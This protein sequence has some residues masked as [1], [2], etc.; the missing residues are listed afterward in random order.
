MASGPTQSRFTESE[1]DSYHSE[2]S[3]YSDEEY[4]YSENYSDQDLIS[5]SDFNEF[6]EEASDNEVESL[7]GTHSRKRELSYDQIVAIRG[8]YKPRPRRKKFAGGRRVYK[9][10]SRLTQGALT[11]GTKPSWTRRAKLLLADAQDWARKQGFNLLRKTWIKKHRIPTWYFR[12]KISELRKRNLR[13]ANLLVFLRLYNIAELAGCKDLPESVPRD[14]H[15]GTD[16]SMY[17]CRQIER[18]FLQLMPQSP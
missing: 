7:Q 18:A 17:F 4:H 1:K 11:R 5:D 14:F 15:L 8:F 9:N 6:I 3:G 13:L 12:T 10:R 16:S 2:R